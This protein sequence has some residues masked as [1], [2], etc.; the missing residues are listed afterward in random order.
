MASVDPVSLPLHDD[1]LKN[2]ALTYAID[3]LCVFPL[4]PGTKKPAIPKDDGGNGF[5]DATTDAQQI[6]QWWGKT[7][8]GANIGIRTSAESNLLVIDVDPRHGGSLEG[9]DG[10]YA[11][12]PELRSTRT[13]AS[14]GGGWHLYLRHP[15]FEVACGADVLGPGIDVKCDGGYIVAHP[16]VHPDGGRYRWIN[17]YDAPLIDCPPV[18]VDS[19]RAH[20]AP[21][22]DA[23]TSDN[24]LGKSTSSSVGRYS[25]PAATLLANALQKTGDG[26]GDSTGYELARKLLA[27]GCG[28]FE[29]HAVLVSYGE[30]ATT[31]PRDPFT[32]RDVRRWIE[33]ARKSEHV[34]RATT[35]EIPLGEITSSS[36]DYTSS[37]AGQGHQQTSNDPDPESLIRRKPGKPFP[38][39][40]V[41]ILGQMPQSK[42]EQLVRG[43]I[44][45][46]T[47][48]CKLQVEAVQARRAG[49]EQRGEELRKHD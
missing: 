19:L 11:R 14:G 44:L 1:H 5:Y 38:L 21:R 33:Q 46:R 12:F 42:P 17:T 8:R 24:P 36:A 9:P 45:K 30:E 39:L 13:A 28:E 37:E 31:N 41:E 34:R 3:G 35:S 40:S 4:R 23:T 7:Y 6:E 15:G 48:C 32:E 18:L 26:V 27:A 43:K 22:H 16:S 47:I 2:W 10:L 29:T 20:T 49:R 25:R